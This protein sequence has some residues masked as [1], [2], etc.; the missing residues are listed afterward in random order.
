MT[1]RFT[2]DELR[3]LIHEI[4]EI[5]EEAGEATLE[6]Y[7]DAEAEYKEDDSPLTQA[8]LEANRIIEEGLGELETVLPVISE[9]SDIPEYE[10]RRE[11][12][13]FWVVDPLDGTKEFL[14]KNDEFTVN[15]GLVEEGR[16]TLGVV[17]APALGVTYFAAAGTGAFKRDGDDG[18][19]EMIEAGAEVPET[20]TVVV[21]RSHI[22]ESTEAFVDRLRETHEVDLMPKGSSLKMCMVAENAAQIYPRLGPTMEWDTMA[23]H[24]VVQQAGA[25]IER[26]DGETLAYNKEELLNPNF[27][28]YSL[29][30]LVPEDWSDFVGE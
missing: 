21:S 1:D 16:P 8:D 14:K 3:D 7:E 22:R 28:V 4:T 9:E 12:E 20:V 13:R 11:W 18:D 6:Y 25:A 30:E 2:E 19:V 5:A 26:P 27:V 23:A 29:R 17:T 10:E 15:I 24:A